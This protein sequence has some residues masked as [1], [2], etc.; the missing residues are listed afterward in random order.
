MEFTLE[1]IKYCLF[2]EP[3][4]M[5]QSYGIPITAQPPV[6]YTQLP[7]IM[8]S[9]LTQWGKIFKGHYN[10]PDANELDN[11]NVM[12]MN[13]TPTAVGK[14]TYLHKI[15]DG[16]DIKK[17][18]NIDHAI[19]LWAMNGFVELNQM[20]DELQLADH[21]FAVE[22]TMA[23]TM[24]ALLDRYVAVI[25]HPTDVD[26]IRKNFIV[27]E[28]S[29]TKGDEKVIVVFFHSYDKNWLLM[30]NFLNQ[31]KKKEN[32]IAIAIG[33]LENFPAFFRNT[34]DLLYNR[35]SFSDTMKVVAR[36]D[37]V[38]DTAVTHSYGRVPIECAC[39][40]VPCIAHRTVES[41]NILFPELVVD[42][43]DLDDIKSAIDRAGK[44]GDDFNYKLYSYNSSA[45]KFLD[46][47]NG[48]EL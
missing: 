30:T 5:R 9:G 1:N 6:R 28:K 16:R 38:I 22:S 8:H 19:D 11:Y 27:D 41:A 34:F 42:I 29:V 2:A 31:L 13:Y 48:G 10:V 12:H 39:L 23:N 33:A 21:L 3:G 44:I 14:L 7:Y 46:M 24:S 37:L 4:W 18:V 25:P 35:V 26:M 47:L 15:I 17:V 40:N 20:L 32:I 43:F 45:D 36:A